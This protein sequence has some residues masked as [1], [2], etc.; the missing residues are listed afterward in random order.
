MIGGKNYEDTFRNKRAQYYMRL[1]DRFYKT[2]RA[3]TKGEYQDPDEMI[4]ISSGIEN[5]D[6][7]RSE[8]CRIPRKYNPNGYFQIMTKREMKVQHKIESPNL[9]DPAMMS[10]EIPRIFKLVL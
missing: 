2:Y 7:F 6:Q 3:V 8:C 5:M 4:S 9:P 10:M 1:R